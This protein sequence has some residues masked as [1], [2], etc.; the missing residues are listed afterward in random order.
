MTE[1]RLKANARIFSGWTS[2]RIVRSIT[3]L[4]HSFSIAIADH[5]DEEE[6]PI[7]A[8]DA[9]SIEYR[10]KDRLT[11]WVSKVD[12]SYDANSDTT[13]FTGAS[14]TIDLVECAAIHGNTGQWRNQDLKKIAEDL[15]QPFGITVQQR[16]NLG[17]VFRKFG[18][19]DGETVFQTLERGA[20]MRNVLVLTD[21][22]GNLYFDRAATNRVSTTIERGKESPIGK[23]VTAR[24]SIDWTNRFSEYRIKAQ[25]TGDSEFFGAACS[26]KKSTTDAAVER[27]RPTIISA[28]NEDSG[29]EL[30]ERVDWERNVRAGQSMTLGYKVLGWE[31]ESGLW[32]P[33][34]LVKVIDSRS[35]INQELLIVSTT[36]VRD[37]RGKTTDI[38]LAIPEAFTVQ[39]LPP[40]K[41]KEKLW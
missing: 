19:Q 15:C 40:P 13:S 11:G 21:S 38:E 6:I 30:Q 1:F 7:A 39:P 35:R 10:N 24:K 8:G 32:E 4:A 31:H 23:I 17:A 36:H 25:L 5:W 20:R 16:V 33:N 12:T 18:V 29:T 27:Y 14:K 26:I 28:E 37:N 34:T 41:E 2:I 3:Q 22:D 9:C